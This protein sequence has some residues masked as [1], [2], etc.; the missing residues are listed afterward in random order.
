MHLALVTL[1]APLVA[2]SAIHRKPTVSGTPSLAT[3]NKDDSYLSQLKQ[4]VNRPQ[5]FCNFYLAQHETRSAVASLTA[6][7]LVE[8]CQCLYIEQK[9]TV[10][11]TG[12]VPPAAKNAVYHCN[13]TAQAVI[14]KAFNDAPTL[15]DYYQASQRGDSPIAVL[16][17]RDMHNG[18]ACFPSANP[19]TSSAS[20]TQSQKP[21]GGSTTPA[22]SS[23]PPQGGATAPPSAAPKATT[24]TSSGPVHPCSGTMPA[25]TQFATSDASLKGSYTATW[26]SFRNATGTFGFADGHTVFPPQPATAALSSCADYVMHLQPNVTDVYDI[27]VFYWNST[28]VN[29]WYCYYSLQGPKAVDGKLTRVDA[30]V[31]CL[32]SYRESGFGKA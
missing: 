7:Q 26:S 3:C 14:Q 22:P 31:E 4:Q 9:R 30:G 17:A 21:K 13:T 23:K 24:T 1:L 27:D 10:P 28:V 19:S 32:W 20:S 29:Q 12:S 18:C 5:V 8:A 6:A 15:C 16:G 11:S 2:S 25:I